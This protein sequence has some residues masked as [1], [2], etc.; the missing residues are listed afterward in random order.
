[1]GGIVYNKDLDSFVGTRFRPKDSFILSLNRY[2][3][4][5]TGAPRYNVKIT[6]EGSS[7]AFPCLNYSVDGR[8]PFVTTGGVLRCTSSLTE[9]IF[10]FSTNRYLKAYMYGYTDGEK[11][12]SNTPSITGGVCTRID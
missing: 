3:A 11:D 8:I 6:D 2:A 7:N 1:M 12:N 9:H 5:D 4:A 10:D